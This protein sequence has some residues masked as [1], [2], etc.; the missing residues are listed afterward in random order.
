MKREPRQE[1]SIYRVRDVKEEV[2]I[3][4]SEQAIVSISSLGKDGTISA[5]IHVWRT[6]YPFDGPRELSP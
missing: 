1:K 4:P 3:K 6:P 5:Y 2:E